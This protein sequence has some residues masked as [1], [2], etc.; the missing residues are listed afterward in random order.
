MNILLTSE[1]IF[2]YFASI[3][4]VHS[5]QY[6]KNVFAMFAIDF[7]S[8][9]FWTSGKSDKRIDSPQLNCSE[10]KKEKKF[11]RKLRKKPKR[12]PQIQLQL[13]RIVQ[14]VH[15]C[16][17]VRSILLKQSKISIITVPSASPEDIQR[18]R[19]AIKK[20]TSLQ[21]VERLTRIL[22]SG[23]IPSNLN[24]ENG[25]GKKIERFDITDIDYIFKSI[26]HIW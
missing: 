26:K 4:F 19:E 17:Y 18:I 2:F 13:S 5:L 10:V 20:A 6:T 23:N 16:S 14:K 11:L 22:Q 9:G 24:A 21:E 12:L 8:C 7:Q 15:H 1:Y 3:I 25:N